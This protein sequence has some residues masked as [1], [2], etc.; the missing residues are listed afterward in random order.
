M[1]S[2]HKCNRCDGT[3]YILVESDNGIGCIPK[4]CRACNG[5]G[6]ILFTNK[7]WLY[8]LDNKAKSE[9]LAVVCS[10]ALANT[11]RRDNRMLTAKFW[12]EWLAKEHSNGEML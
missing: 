1:I 12:E 5:T 2:V 6:T 10:K 4:P 9:W 11:Q 3:G 8:Q 7:D